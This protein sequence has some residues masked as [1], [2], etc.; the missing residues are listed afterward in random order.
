MPAILL[1]VST[2]VERFT[3]TRHD[4]SYEAIGVRVYGYGI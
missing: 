2:G 4:I 1:P 3:K